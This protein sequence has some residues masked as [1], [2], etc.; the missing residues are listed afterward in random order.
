[1][2]GKFGKKIIVCKIGF[3]RGL[4][5]IPFQE[6]N[7]EHILTN[8]IFNQKFKK[9]KRSLNFLTQLKPPY[10]PLAAVA[11]LNSALFKTAFLIMKFYKF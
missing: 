11:I 8:V 1:M 10:P 2:I 3:F 6:R 4:I 7:N 9:F 5:V